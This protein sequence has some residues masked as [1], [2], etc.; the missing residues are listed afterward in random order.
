MTGE[1]PSVTY[2]SPFGF[3]GH[4]FV[5]N[6]KRY[7]LEENSRLLNL[8]RTITHGNYRL[9]DPE[10]SQGHVKHHFLLN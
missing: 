10:S 2:F 9:Y 3:H 1:A 7:T 6:Q 8:L 4:S 5:P